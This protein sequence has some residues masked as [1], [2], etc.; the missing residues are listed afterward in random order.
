MQNDEIVNQFIKVYGIKRLL[1]DFGEEKIKK[2]NVHYMCCCPFHDERAPSF[3]IEMNSGLFH[4]FACDVSGNL[5]QFV[6]KKLD[7]SYKEAIQYIKKLAGFQSTQNIEDLMFLNQM[8]SKLETEANVKKEE[9]PIIKI[10]EKVLKNMNTGSDPY[11]YLQKRG[12]SQETIEDFECTFTNKWRR[13]NAD[14][15]KYF[16]EERVIIP[17][18]DTKGNIIGFAGRTPLDAQPK[19]LYTY[20]FAKSECLFNLHRA[21]KYT[22]EG[23]IIVEGPLDAMQ[24]WNIGFKNVV[25]IYGASPSEEQISLISRYTDKVYL[26]FDNDKAGHNAFVKAI[27][28]LKDKVDINVL[29]INPYKD[30]GEIKSREEFQRIL[31]NSYNW[32]DFQ[33]KNAQ[34]GIL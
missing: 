31:D 19:Y 33:L 14:T 4:C 27:D 7:I 17:L 26:S 13:M 20:G 2:E 5:Y 3:G 1:E 18:H 11:F 22:N 21:K 30:P 29:N 10:D 32:H 15:N 24:L 8:K 28:G 6:V 25:S 12:F 16:F 23:L 34:P 9:K